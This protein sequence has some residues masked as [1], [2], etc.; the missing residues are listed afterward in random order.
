M[1]FYNKVSEYVKYIDPYLKD[2]NVE[3]Q[4]IAK[5]EEDLKSELYEVTNLMKYQIYL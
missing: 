3:K 1:D 4:N 5:L 2:R